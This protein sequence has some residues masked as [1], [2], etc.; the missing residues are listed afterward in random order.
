MARSR[1]SLGPAMV[2][3]ALAL[4]CAPPA[5]TPDVPATVASAIAEDR[6]SRDSGRNAWLRAGRE[7]FLLEPH[8]R[9]VESGFQGLVTRLLASSGPAW[10][11]EDWDKYFDVE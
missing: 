10:N 7:F 6:R 9:Q 8:V 5:P 4:A 3:V 2:L 1:R 11:R